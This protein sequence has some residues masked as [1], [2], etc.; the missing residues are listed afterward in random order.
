M[1]TIE[2]MKQHVSVRS[3][4]KKAIPVEVKQELLLAA[5]SGSTSNFVQ[6]YSII[7]IGDQAKKMQLAEITKFPD[8]C[9]KRR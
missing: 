9:I 5:Q 8:I 7:E 3:Y 4:Q 2:Q 6:A 1:H